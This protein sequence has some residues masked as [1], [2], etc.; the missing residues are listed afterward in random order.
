VSAVLLVGAVASFGALGSA[1]AAPSLAALALRQSDVPAGYKQT[2]TKYDT[3]QS[4]ASSDHVSVA[5]LRSKGWLGSYQSTFAKTSKSVSLEISSGVD[6]FKSASG[7]NWDISNG[8]RILKAELH[9][10]KTFPVSGIGNQAVG[11]R[12]SGK[13]GKTAY[14]IVYVIFRRGSYLGGAGIF[15]AGAVKSG[16]ATDAERYARIVD[17]RLKNT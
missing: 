4:A 10:S 14:S 1:R 2:T 6:H 16:S 3:I 12:V 9:G 13:S 7:V 11:L 17:G 15:A 8:L 5:T